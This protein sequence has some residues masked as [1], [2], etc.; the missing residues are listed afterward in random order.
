M[1]FILYRFAIRKQLVAV[2]KNI[3]E[4]GLIYVNVIIFPQKYFSLYPQVARKILFMLPTTA[5]NVM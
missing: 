2:Y 1:V 4:T 5:S 3:I